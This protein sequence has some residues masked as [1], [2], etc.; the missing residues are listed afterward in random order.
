MAMDVM[1]T[2]YLS[3]GGFMVF[4]VGIVILV[5]SGKSIFYD[6]YRKVRP[7]GVDVFVVNSNRQISQHY[8]VPKDGQIKINKLMYFTNTDKVMSLSDDMKKEVVEGIRKKN[9][10]I[11]ELIKDF[12]DKKKNA[13]ELLSKIDDNAINKGEIEQ[14]KEY[15]E[16]LNQRIKIL[17]EKLNTREQVYYNQRRG[18]FFF[19]E[20]DP[21]PKDFHEQYTEMDCITIDNVIA[22]SMTKD[23]KAVRN[24]E[25][26]L[27]ILKFL[28]IVTGIC[29]AGAL[30]LGILLKTD[31]T[32]MARS[33]GVTLTL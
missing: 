3:I 7:K 33:M 21:I 28:I 17:K 11:K 13:E 10:K 23:P 12:E 8:K 25:K 2:M 1:T 24:M 19:I 18:A 5:V 14:F 31:I 15:I 32:T 22:R 6:F 20:G 9:V 16:T 26:E 29:A 30:V 27:K 4:S